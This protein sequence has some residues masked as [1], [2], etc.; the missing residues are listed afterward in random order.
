MVLM[1]DDTTPAQPKSWRTTACA[2]AALVAVAATAIKYQ[3][4][5]DPATVPDWTSLVAITM[6]AI[7]GLFARDAAA[8]KEAAKNA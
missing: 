7:S 5:G 4:D 6:T 1:P 3:F 2:I 8:S